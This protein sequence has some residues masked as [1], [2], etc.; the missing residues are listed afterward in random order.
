VLLLV[1]SA[2]KRESLERL[3]SGR[4]TPSFPASMLQMHPDVTLLC[5][6]APCSNALG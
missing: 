1:T 5:D 6:A 4:I 3:L 2:A